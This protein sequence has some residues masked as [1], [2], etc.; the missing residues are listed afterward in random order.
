MMIRMICCILPDRRPHLWWWSSSQPALGAENIFRLS[1]SLSLNYYVLPNM[2][3]GLRTFLET[4]LS[5]GSCHKT[6]SF[7]NVHSFDQQ[8]VQ[9]RE[10]FF[11]WYFIISSYHIFLPEPHRGNSI[12]IFFSF[13]LIIFSYLH[14]RGRGGRCDGGVSRGARCVGCC[15]AH[16]RDNIV[17]VVIIGIMLINW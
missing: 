16:L 1:L 5:H 4:Y 17:I 11:Y 10:D 3:W 2:P 15:W 9:H 6:S 12:C 7:D 8:H 14:R 13:H